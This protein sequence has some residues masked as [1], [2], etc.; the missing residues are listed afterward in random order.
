MGILDSLIVSGT[1]EYDHRA[2][3][4]KLP[5]VG[6]QHSLRTEIKIVSAVSFH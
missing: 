3:R 4:T 2:Q 1:W 5:A 6:R